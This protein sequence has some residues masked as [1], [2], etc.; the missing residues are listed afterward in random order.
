MSHSETVIVEGSEYH[1]VSVCSQLFQHSKQCASQLTASS[2][3][4]YHINNTFSC[5][6][7]VKEDK[8][9]WKTRKVIFRLLNVLAMTV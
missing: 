6:R 5:K 7:Y 8:R 3:C 1:S 2:V 4:L 9:L